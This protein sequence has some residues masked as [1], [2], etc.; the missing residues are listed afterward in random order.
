M[1]TSFATIPTLSKPSESATISNGSVS[2]YMGDHDGYIEL[3]EGAQLTYTVDGSNIDHIVVSADGNYLGTVSSPVIPYTG[4]EQVTDLA[5]VGIHNFNVTAYDSSGVII[6]SAVFNYSVSRD[7]QAWLTITNSSTGKTYRG[8]IANIAGTVPDGNWIYLQGGKPI[9][10]PDLNLT[11]DATQFIGI[12]MGAMGYTGTITGD[13]QASVKYNT[14]SF[15]I[16]T[17]GIDNVAIQSTLDASLKY[18][19]MDLQVGLINLSRASE[20]SLEGSLNKQ[21]L[22]DDGI[23]KN[24]GTVHTDANGDVALPGLPS[25]LPPGTYVLVV[26]D[27][28][29]TLPSGI[30]LIASAPVIVTQ[31]AMTVDLFNAEDI[32]KTVYNPGDTLGIDETL[33]SAPSK[34]YFY[35][36]FTIPEQYYYGNL[37]INAVNAS[38]KGINMSLDAFGVNFTGNVYDTITKM[39]HNITWARQFANDTLASAQ[40]K[41]ANDTPITPGTEDILSIPLGQNAPLGRYVLITAVFDTDTLSIVAVNSTTFDV[42]PTIVDYN[43]SL[44]TGWNLVSYPV[45]NSTIKAS[46]LKGTCVLIVASYNRTTGDFDAFNTVS[47]PL[48]YDIT[49]HTDAGYF[50]YSTHDTTITVS[51]PNSSGRSS[52]IFQGWNLIGWS[53]MVSSNAKTVCSEPSLAGNQ[54]IAKYNLTTGDFDAYAENISSDTYN[55]IMQNGVGYFVYSGSATPQTLYY[56]GI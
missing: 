32:S 37:S 13:L 12:T 54:I 52:P 43:I 30:G 45:V 14:N 50:I 8:G 28:S 26:Y 56:E 49:M 44:K 15:P 55:F 29:L 10:A 6:Q 11:L 36:A 1:V 19:N 23:F 38:I 31:S 7:Y 41:F 16:Y 46:D 25:N 3:G 4:T 33:V 21:M 40:F 2:E 47:S 48:S 34:Q 39:A 42:T 53:S 9:A 24:I 22:I 5:T 20:I 17:D 27:N 51:G 35:T 18:A